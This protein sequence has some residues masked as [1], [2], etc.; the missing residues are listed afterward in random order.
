MVF[1]RIQQKRV[2]C[3]CVCSGELVSVYRKAHL[4]DVE[5][6]SKGVSL[7]ESAFTVPGPRLVAPVQ[8]PIGKVLQPKTR[9]QAAAG[10][11]VLILGCTVMLS[12]CCVRCRSVLVS[13]TI[14]VF[15]S[16]HQRCGDTEQRSSLTPQPSLWPQE[17]H[18][19][20]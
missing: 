9:T 11:S 2:V 8:T 20:R 19:G 7:K 6:T 3:V 13:A 10:L 16:F 15:L 18:T 12:W 14:C 17:R 4:F 5:L 1:C